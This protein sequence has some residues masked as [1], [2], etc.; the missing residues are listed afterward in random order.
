[1]T[2]DEKKEARNAWV[3]VLHPWFDQISARGTDQGLE[4]WNLLG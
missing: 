2:E 4:K 1:M 3:S